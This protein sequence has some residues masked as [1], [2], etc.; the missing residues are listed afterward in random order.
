MHRRVAGFAA[1]GR[2]AR[3]GNALAIDG[4]GLVPR[5]RRGRRRRRLGGERLSTVGR[6]AGLRRSSS[7]GGVSGSCVRASRSPLLSAASTSSA[8]RRRRRSRG[9]PARLRACPAAG[10]T[11]VR[12]S[13]TGFSSS[14]IDSTRRPSLQEKSCSDRRGPGSNSTAKSRSPA[15]NAVERDAEQVS[16]PDRSCRRRPRPCA[17]SPRASRDARRPGRRSAGRALS[18]GRRRHPPA[19]SSRR[20]SRPVVEPDRLG[21][22]ACDRWQRRPSC[23]RA[24]PRRAP[25]SVA[26]SVPRRHSRTVRA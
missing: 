14:R 15:R 1:P 13:N 19:R 12:I 18:V 11:G 7:D 26:G 6:L 22:L 3:I 23:S 4:Y 17:A 9:R 20:R 8:R 10:R 2:S 21:R 5:H 16:G 24:A 25:A